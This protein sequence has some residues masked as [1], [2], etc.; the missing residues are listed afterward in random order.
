MAHGIRQGVSPLGPNIWGKVL[1][2]DGAAWTEQKCNFPMLSLSTKPK[3][4]RETDV[5]MHLEILTTF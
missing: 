3:V 2:K 5:V 1:E 4:A